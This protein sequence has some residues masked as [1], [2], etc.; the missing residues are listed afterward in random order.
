MAIPEVSLRSL[1]ILF[2][3][4]NLMNRRIVSAMLERR[5]HVVTA[6][7]NGKEVLSE[8]LRSFYDVVLMDIAMPEIDGVKATEAIRSSVTDRVDASIPI[9]ALT[10]H[11]M[12]SDRE[13]YIQAGMDGFLSK[14]V[15]INALLKT[16]HDVLV[17]KG[18]TVEF[19]TAN[20][21]ARVKQGELRGLDSIFTEFGLERDDVYAL[22]VL[23]LELLPREFA[24][25]KLAVEEGLLDKT[26][27]LA[28]SL[29][30]SALDI[31]ADGP[32]LLAREIEYAAR[33]GDFKEV[34]PLCAEMEPQIHFVCQEMRRLMDA[35][36]I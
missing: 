19:D 6:V 30:G 23:M 36:G 10:A 28:H 33:N 32:A 2:A 22:Y 35:N 17:S 4:D 9:V 11:Y 34:R 8:L 18:R 14:P 7:S 16:I 26:A 25:L 5:G 12:E 13:R 31:I 21:V 24:A 15:R 20:V 1:R 27:E 29:A 3:D